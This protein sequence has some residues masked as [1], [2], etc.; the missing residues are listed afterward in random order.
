M[1]ASTA[2]V[3]VTVHRLPAKPRKRPLVGPTAGRVPC[4]VDSFSSTRRGPRFRVTSCCTGTAFAFTLPECFGS[5]S[6]RA[7][8]EFPN[9]GRRRRRC[10][11]RRTA[12][13]ADPAVFRVT[14]YYYRG[15]CYKAFWADPLRAPSASRARLSGRLILPA[16]YSERHRYM[17]FLSVG[18]L[19]AWASTCGKR[20]R[21]PI[22][23]PARL[24]SASRRYAFLAIN[25]V[26]LRGYLLGTIR[27]RARRRAGASTSCL[28]RRWPSHLFV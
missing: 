19:D 14:C 18:V 11:F 21:R 10:R 2:P 15:A 13:P 1:A 28:P 20:C 7:W 24:R 8:F 25:V 3:R 12:D 9:G 5:F 27:C 23:R 4:A 6:A 17:L 22:R 26:L 16:Q